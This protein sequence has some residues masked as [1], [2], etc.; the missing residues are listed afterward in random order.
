MST[1]VDTNNIKHL[2]H[3]ILTEKP[4]FVPSKKVY[5]KLYY[6]KATVP[7]EK[8]IDSYKKRV[9]KRWFST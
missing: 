3:N 1:K 9:T 4:E 6:L 2:L 7:T 8:Q 5:E